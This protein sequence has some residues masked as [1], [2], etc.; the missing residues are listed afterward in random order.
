MTQLLST[1]RKPIMD[2]LQRFETALASSLSSDSAPMVAV[3]RYVSEAR[4]KR[5][6][7]MT[8]FLSARLFGET[9]ETA[10]RTALFVEMLHTATLI[11]D[12]IVDGSD[13]RRG[14]KAV[15]V[16]WDSPSAVLAGDFLLAKAMMQL[17]DPDSLPI[18]REMLTTTMAMSEGEME[19]NGN[20]KTED[21][22][23]KTEGEYLELIKRKTALLFRSC[24]VGG[25]MAALEKTEERSKKIEGMGAFGMYLG[26]VFQM[27]DDILDA[28]DPTTVG[29]AQKLL[30]LYLDKTLKALEALAP[31]AKNPEV[32]DTLRDLVVFCAERNQ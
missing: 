13:E 1:I 31:M 22:R 32:L 27:R 18:L 8:V 29:F 21:R 3:L 11:H 14:R 15:H 7:P 24:C 12:D 6:R 25:A 9:N 5:L 19:E 23:Q 20:K 2:D 26:L 28:D 30:P 4:G 16:R 10:M 17:S